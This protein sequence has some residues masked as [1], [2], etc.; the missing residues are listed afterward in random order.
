MVNF[1]CSVCEKPFGVNHEAVCCD[2][3]NKR[4]HTRCNSICK[5]LIDFSRKT[6]HHGIVNLYL[7]RT[8]IF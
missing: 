7:S 8:S 5:K 2:K 4:V 3:C 6:Q 1:P